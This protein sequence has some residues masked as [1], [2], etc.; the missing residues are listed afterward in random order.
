MVSRVPGISCSDAH[1]LAN[2]AGVNPPSD[3]CGLQVLYSI[4]Q[5]STT[6][7][8]SASEPNSSMLSS[9]SRSRPL[10]DST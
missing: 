5:A 7:R 3:E 4:R 6:M 10:K 1:L 8:A 9:S 2:S